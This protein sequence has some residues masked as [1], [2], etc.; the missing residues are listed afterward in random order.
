MY[1][2]WVKKYFAK[3]GRPAEQVIKVKNCYGQNMYKMYVLI[4]NSVL[5]TKNKQSQ[6]K[7]INNKTILEIKRE[8]TILIRRSL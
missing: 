3:I 5:Y 6:Y 2:D 4:S 7:N 1:K 8:L